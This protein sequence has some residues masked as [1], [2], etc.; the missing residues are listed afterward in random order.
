[1]SKKVDEFLLGSNCLEKQ[2]AQWDFASGTVTPGDKLITVHRRHRAGICRRVIV[3]H[4]C[5][6]PTKHEANV[7]VRMVDEGIPSR[8]AIGPGVMAARI[9]FSDS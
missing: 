6:V 3:T 1:V 4:D 2:G 5:V 8:R 9:L 7:S